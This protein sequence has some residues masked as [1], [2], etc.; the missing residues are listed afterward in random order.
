MSVIKKLAGQ[1]AVYGLSSI[2]G[3]LLNYF[4]VPLHTTIFLEK[5][6]GEVSEFYSYVAFFAVML[7]FGM[8]TTFF[9]FVNKSEDKEKTFNQALSIVLA[10]NALFLLIVFG[11]SGQLA[12]LMGY[13]QYQM[14]VIWFACILAFDA[15]SS[16][17]LAKLRFLN[18]AKKFAIIQ[19]SSI[20]V[21]IF[22]NLFFLLFLIDYFP[23][24]GIGF[25][26]LANLFASLIKPLMLYKEL[27]S[28]RF[29][30]D[31]ALAKS[32]I[33]F[34]VPLLIA[35]FA[36]IINETLDRIL[37]K[38]LLLDQGEDFAKTQVGI[39]SANYKLAIFI[40]IFI[41][42]FRYAAEPFFFA[43]EKSVDK[44]KVY[45]KVMT[46]FVIV[47]ALMFLVIALN[48]DIFK[49]FIPN[50]NYHVGLVVVPVLL[51]ANIC[52]GIYY[53]QSI[54]YK[55]AD[56]TKFG[57]YIAIGGATITILL[58]VILIPIFGYVGSAWA[59]LS[60]YFSMMV[61]SYLLGKK[62]YPIKYN[63]RKV[64]LYLFTSVG[65]YFLGLLLSFESKAITFVV[66]S[67]LILMFIGLVMFMERPLQTL[68][69]K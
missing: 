41:Q 27:S 26:F 34:A 65:L 25:I 29:T 19:L 47:V 20:G 39:Y 24:T 45:S 53:N 6:Y 33:V 17:L 42:A 10:V 2:I 48:L 62:H 37:L 63:L 54:W 66:H 28:F 21:N 61:A 7:T 12:S 13:P 36:G 35:S 55:L 31:K 9:R 69:K 18:Q 23:D 51:L 32:M 67:I 60:C 43:H 52:L 30:I 56:K 46:W 22:L 16:V 8:E 15:S 64:G 3:R 38:N 40:T 49:W 57:A 4:L 5:E 11:F 50:E 1:T 14:Y 59:T 68:R 44:N 58:N